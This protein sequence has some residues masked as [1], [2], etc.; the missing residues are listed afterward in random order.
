MMPQ[1]YKEPAAHQNLF[2]E[3]PILLC[4]CA[5]LIGGGSDITL[6]Y[7]F[8]SL[9][10]RQMLNVETNHQHTGKAA[11]YL[12]FQTLSFRKLLAFASHVSKLAHIYDNALSPT[13]DPMRVVRKNNLQ[14]VAGSWKTKMP[15]RTVP[16]APIPVHTG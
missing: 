14:N 12:F 5:V 13:I 11:L 9:L 7:Q 1:S 2:N 8:N 16:T 3:R 6:L 4:E 10:A 15:T